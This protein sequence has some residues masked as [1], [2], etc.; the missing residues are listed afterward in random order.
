[1]QI[2]KRFGEILVE[3]GVITDNILTAALQAQKK[4]GLALG[5]I[6]EDMGAISDWDIAT[7]LARQFNLRAV[8]T[9]SAPAIRVCSSSPGRNF[10]RYA[11]PFQFR[12][13]METSFIASA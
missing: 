2:R 7:I 11:F 9:I 1:M 8:Q 10:S 4:S 3:A 12:I 6:L 13:T 5:R